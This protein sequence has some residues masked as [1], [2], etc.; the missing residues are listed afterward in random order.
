MYANTD[1]VGHVV[2]FHVIALNLKVQKMC[3]A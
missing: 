3:C 1:L 2:I